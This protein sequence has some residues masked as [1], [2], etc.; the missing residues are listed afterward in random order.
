VRILFVIA[1]NIESEPL[2]RFLANYESDHQKR[3]NSFK[4]NNLDIDVLTTGMGISSTIYWLTKTLQ[5]NRYDICFNLGICGSYS[6][7]SNIGDVYWVDRESFANYGFIDESVFKHAFESKLIKEETY[8]RDNILH[9]P[10]TIKIDTIEALNKAQ[11]ATVINYTG[12]VIRSTNAFVPQIET[13]EGAAFFFVCL[14]E[15]IPFFELRSIS[16][17]VIQQ[18]KKQW[19]I[20]LAIKTLSVKVKEILDELNAKQL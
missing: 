8:F 19:N 2:L 13:M 20:P 5:N 10:A 7:S 1:T 4:Y 16:N 14:L 12:E 15:K 3:I 11:G 9:S 18:D 6:H 17:L